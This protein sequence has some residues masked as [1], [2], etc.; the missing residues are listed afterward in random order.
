MLLVVLRPPRVNVDIFH[1]NFPAMFIVLTSLLVNVGVSFTSTYANETI[2]QFAD[3]AYPF[4]GL[5]CVP[6]SR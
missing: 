1:K 4:I 5:F 3:T 2:D 6:W